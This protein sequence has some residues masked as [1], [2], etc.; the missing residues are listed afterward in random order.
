[1]NLFAPT[2][3]L[4]KLDAVRCNW[5][6]GLEEALGLLPK[7]DPEGVLWN[8]P[9]H[10]RT[11]AVHGNQTE[12]VKRARCFPA[13]GLCHPDACLLGSIFAGGL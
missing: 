10:L 4:P 3:D 1:M 12:G 7:V 13:T 8:S 2:G 11:S 9:A 6:I 5:V